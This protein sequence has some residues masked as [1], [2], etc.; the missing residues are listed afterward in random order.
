MGRDTQVIVVGGGLAGLAAATVAAR[1]GQRVEVLEARSTLGGRARTA[2]RNGFHVNEGA[3]ALYRGGEGLAVLRSLGIEPKGGVPATTGTFG[4]LAGRLGV[5]PGGP[6]SLARTR[7][8]GARGKV[9]IAR[10]LAG[11][12][13]VDAAAL[14]T[15]SIGDW[16]ADT[17]PEADAA[18]LLH[19]LVRLTTYVDDP[20]HLSA[21]AAVGQLQRAV[22]DSVLYLHGGWQRLVDDLAA[23]ARTAGVTLRTRAKVERIVPVDG[24]VEVRADGEVLTASNVVLAAGGPHA[25]GAL[26]EGAATAGGEAARPSRAAS[27]DLCFAGAWGGPGFVIGLDSSLYVSNHSRVARVAPE[28]ATLV[29]VMKY[30]GADTTTAAADDR[31]ELEAAL[32]TVRPGWRDDAIDVLYRPRLVSATDV[33]NASTGGLGGR[34]GPTV[35]G[36]PGVLV[37]GDWVG[38]A[39]ML[40]DA[41][42]ASGA[43]AGRLAAA[44][45][46]GAPARA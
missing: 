16:I 12:P 7:L 43:A 39:G 10:L 26:V 5:L 22:A 28:G 40:S 14:G 19:A 4:L 2:E 31:A 32:D 17:A 1:A 21:D 46:R 6:M 13:K 8:L 38:P 35:P 34:P 41:A 25:P 15:T 45:G 42:L 33:P 30:L 44:A 20:G 23:A 37:A 36:A 18:R 24:G 3:H 9:R 11:L 27:L 29:S